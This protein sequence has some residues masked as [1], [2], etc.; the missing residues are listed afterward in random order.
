MTPRERYLAT[1]A[2][3]KPDQVPIQLGCRPEIMEQLRT[4]YNVETDGDVARILG[5][6]MCRWAHVQTRWRE[7]EKKANDTLN[8]CPVIRHD[9]RTFEDS[10]GV[11]E[12]SG[13]DGKYLEWVSGPFDHTD[14]IDSFP[15][16]D[17]SDITL[18]PQTQA[19]RVAEFK[20]QGYW[21]AADGGVHP[22]KQAW[23][24]R[25]FENFLCDYIANPDWV[26]Q[27]YDRLV[28]FNVA[29]C[30]LLAQAGV[31]MIEYW[32]DVAM[33]DRM[34]VPPDQWRRLD[35]PVWRRIISE[36]RKVNPDVKFFFHS[37]G[38]VRPIIG[39]IIEV[40]FDI[41]NP[42]QPECVNPGLVKRQWGD[43]VTLDGGG[44][45]QRT[46]PRG[47]LDDVRREVDFL[48]TT[49]AYNGG[50]ILRAS[51]VVPYDTPLEN[52]ILFYEMARDY[53]MSRLQGPPRHIPDPP[54]CMSV[55][56][57]TRDDFLP[58]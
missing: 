35:K 54:P 32:G 55:A 26:E 30:R 50:F 42:L 13:S 51:N 47:K 57:F 53:D 6:D 48:M 25:G 5:A 22:F 31:D 45:V 36:T 1:L 40:G 4:H 49:C 33:Q 37:D 29:H 12:R 28:S 41:L 24:M 34:I 10:W 7:F 43:K 38:D 20:K 17:A 46:L 44:S 21:V 3:V 27:L 19:A 39:D 56:T 9:A 52:V 18:H 2:H 16:P 58:D 15:W 11:V 8:G 14:R 23:H